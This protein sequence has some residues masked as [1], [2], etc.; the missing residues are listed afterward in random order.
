[1]LRRWGQE[2]IEKKEEEEEEVEDDPFLE[3]PVLKIAREM[4]SKT[5]D[6]S[7]NQP[8]ISYLRKAMNFT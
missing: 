6:E 3:Q 7:C 2:D 1:M 8:F 5:Q 4:I